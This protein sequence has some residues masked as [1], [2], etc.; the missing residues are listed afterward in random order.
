M[1]GRHVMLRRFDPEA[2]VVLKPGQDVDE[3]DLIQHCQKHLSRFKIPKS[4]DFVKSLI[5][6][7]TSKILKRE[8]REK[9]W[10]GFEKRVH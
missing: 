4:F 8:L 3:N 2:I 6:S 5:K 1:G 10:K 7:G 9:Y